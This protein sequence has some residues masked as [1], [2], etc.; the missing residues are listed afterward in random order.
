[1]RLEIDVGNRNHTHILQTELDNAGGVE[2]MAPLLA[3]LQDGDRHRVVDG[4]ALEAAAEAD[5]GRLRAGGADRP[6]LRRGLVHV[7]GGGAAVKAAIRR[8]RQERLDLWEKK[9]RRMSRRRL[10]EEGKLG[11]D[12]HDG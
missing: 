9:L 3:V 11:E 7:G 10:E 1:M 2:R 8:K 4:G 12:G 5:G 6:P